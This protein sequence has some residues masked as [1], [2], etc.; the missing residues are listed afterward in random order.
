MSEPAV[1]GSRAR[2][3]GSALSTIAAIAAVSHFGCNNQFSPPPSPPTDNF[4]SGGY[5][6]GVGGSGGGRNPDGGY[7]VGG[8]GGFGGY[9]GYGVGGYGV[10]GYHPYGGT[11]GR[12]CLGVY[13]S[14][15]PIGASCVNDPLPPSCDTTTGLWVCP[16]GFTTSPPDRSGCGVGGAGGGGGQCE[17]LPVLGRAGASGAAGATGAGGAQDAGAA[18]DA[19]AAADAGAGD[20]GVGGAP[21]RPALSFASPKYYAPGGPP[22]QVAVADMN[23]DGH[24]DI[25]VTSRSDGASANWKVNV[26]LNAGDGTFSA[27]ASFPVSSWD[28][29]YMA[30]GDLNGD[31]KPDVAIT[32]T[33]IGGGP[34]SVDVLLNLGD[35]LAAP[36]HNLIAGAPQALVIADVDG[37]GRNDLVAAFTVFPTSAGVAVLSNQ[38]GGTFAAART[39]S[40][41]TQPSGIA[42]GDLNRDGRIDLAVINYDSQIPGVNDNLDVLL[43]QGGGNFAPP[44]QYAS[45]EFL[46]AVAEADL[47]GDNQPDLAVLDSS[48]NV[49]VLLNEGTGSFVGPLRYSAQ[50]P[51]GAFAL[52]DVTGDGRIDI[53]GAVPLQYGAAGWTYGDVSVLVNGGDAIFSQRVDFSDEPIQGSIALGDL[54][55]DGKLDVVAVNHT[56]GCI[57]S[58]SVLLNTSP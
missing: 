45:G 43:N 56:Y 28:S 13:P 52:G 2:R 50:H 49:S 44:V 4:G 39:F 9:G 8:Y 10:G 6:Y 34:F 25:V 41:G 30:V 55:G 16:A 15:W 36:N 29:L 47:N 7:G 1:P 58:I 17:I 35:G 21:A 3:W 19:G 51:A 33:S 27:P 54:N 12:Q 40:V 32:S 23:G 53:V 37:N 22:V 5:I 24:L 46:T 42:A 20:A 31:G 18:P 14:C 48:S 11:G 26:L 38:G 57:D